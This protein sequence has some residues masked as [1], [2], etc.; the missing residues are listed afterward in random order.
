MHKNIRNFSLLSALLIR[1]IS[2]VIRAFYCFVFRECRHMVATA[3]DS[4]SL[5]KSI[6]L[7]RGHGRFLAV[8]ADERRYGGRRRV[9]EKKKR[10]KEKRGRVEKRLVLLPAYPGGRLSLV[11]GSLIE[12]ETSSTFLESA[13]CGLPLPS[14]SARSSP[15]SWIRI[16]VIGWGRRGLRNLVFVEWKREPN[17]SP[18][19]RFISISAFLSLS[20][21][22]FSASSG[23]CRA[24]SLMIRLLP[25]ALI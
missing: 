13:C 1:N 11:R 21:F 4:G 20:F 12:G 22:R 2:I 18:F 23:G 17:H 19:V 6:G 15:Q 3:P 16:V 10:K 9:K 5:S 7:L 14:P 25:G 24:I 8:A